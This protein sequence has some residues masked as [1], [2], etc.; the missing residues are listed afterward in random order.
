MNNTHKP[1]LIGID[2]GSTTVKAAAIQP[3]SYELLAATYRRHHAHQL[4]TAIEVLAELEAQL[5][6][7]PAHLAVTGS[8]GR[9]LADALGAPYVQEV[10]ANSIAVATHHPRARVAIELGG[11][12]AKMI[13][14]EPGAS[15]GTPKVSDMRMNGSCAGGTGAFL[16]E[17]ASLLK[18]P[19]EQLDDLAARG[20]TLYAISGRCGVF[21]KTDIQP[22]VNQGAAKEDIAL[23]TFHAVAKQTLGGLAQGL[24][25]IPPVIFEGGPLT[26]N[27]T[28]VRVFCERLH[29]GGADAIVPDNPEI[30]V[31]RGAAL[32]LE[33]ASSAPAPASAP[34]QECAARGLTPNGARTL[35][36]AR[37]AIAAFA[38]QAK[39]KASSSPPL[40]ESAEELA[41]F[42]ARHA[43]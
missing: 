41:A 25:V 9:E 4:Q 23:S 31:A 34:D 13:F 3:D 27:P 12:D 15:D 11:Q 10:I 38:K 6:N 40:F 22:L 33:K 29:I 32:A 26:F 18:V 37:D 7:M 21:A 43:L 36:E 17:I 30:I 42:R 35:A 39:G 14:F 28:L 8:G 1:V 24:E 19:V 16:D 2:V 20:T 5:G